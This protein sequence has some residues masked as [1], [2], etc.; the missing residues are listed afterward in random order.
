MF[1]FVFVCSI[2]SKNCADTY[3]AGERYS[4]VYKIKPDAS[5]IIEVFCDQTTAGG[6]WLVFQKRLNGSVDFY[7]GWTEY[8]R[9]FGFLT[10]EFWLGLD[11]I[12][13]LTSSRKYKLRVDLEDFSRQITYA[14]YDLFE[15][16]SEGE[17][18]NLSLGSY[19]GLISL[20]L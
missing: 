13:H 1:C 18:Y 11:K 5:G 6:G 20:G 15:V 10:G 16:A 2:V 14:E 12:H 19:A 8:K 4:G 9:G 7:R 3:N 17:K